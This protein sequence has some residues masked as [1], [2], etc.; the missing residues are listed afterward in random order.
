MAKPPKR[1]DTVAGLAEE[2]SLLA[3]SL[4]HE[5]RQPLT[6]IR[7]GLELLARKAYAVVDDVPRNIAKTTLDAV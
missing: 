7:A 5:M 3:P 2:A 6:G 1:F 4:I